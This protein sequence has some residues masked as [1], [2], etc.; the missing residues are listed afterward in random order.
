MLDTCAGLV[1]MQELR[2]AT[3]AFLADRLN[4][5]TYV[6]TAEDIEELQEATAVFLAEHANG[7]CSCLGPVDVGL[8][9]PDEQ[10]L[11][12]ITDAV[13]CIRGAAVSASDLINLIDECVDAGW[14][15][16]DSVDTPLPD[17]IVT[18]LTPGAALSRTLRLVTSSGF[19]EDQSSLQE[20]LYDAI[21]GLLGQRAYINSS[22]DKHGD[23]D[24]DSTDDHANKAQDQNGQAFAASDI[25]YRFKASNAA[26]FFDPMADTVVPYASFDQPLEIELT[27]PAAHLTDRA[28]LKVVT[29][30]PTILEEEV[31][32]S[33][34]SDAS[35]DF[36]DHCGFLKSI[37]SRRENFLDNDE[38]LD[39]AGELHDDEHELV[40]CNAGAED[41]ES[42]FGDD[43]WINAPDLDLALPA[44]K[45][46]FS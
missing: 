21:N 33:A 14:A 40:S 3:A 13:N 7:D 31:Q 34:A 28:T 30:L 22:A 38:E 41:F 39:D 27:P 17:A 24:S 37:E 11:L 19:V 43:I 6:A 12:P 25:A 2:S 1:M 46:L 42:F 44:S 18:N 16:E 15:Y 23:T 26:A 8:L 5:G 29:K 32:W 20:E 36:A 4:D 9:L 45:P 10:F 35:I